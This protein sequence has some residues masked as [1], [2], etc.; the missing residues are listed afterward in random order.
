MSKEYINL[1]K[2]FKKK[3]LY[4]MH[5]EKDG[6]SNYQIISN[7]RM[8][9]TWSWFGKKNLTNFKDRPNNNLIT[10]FIRKK[11]DEEKSNKIYDECNHLSLRNLYRR[12][13]STS[14]I[15]VIIIFYFLPFAY[16]VKSNLMKKFGFKRYLAFL[17]FLLSAKSCIE[18]INE[19]N[20][21]K[22]YLFF[23][24]GIES[25]YKDKNCVHG[26]I[27]EDYKEFS[28]KNNFI[29]KEDL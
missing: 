28:I 23:F 20:I 1:C 24:L 26:K 21:N 16:L 29:F 6:N 11:L 14:Y 2:E 17:P 13:I 4:K 27:Y 8:R 3:N 18:I 15:K 5:L 25:L 9:N 10:F 12:T 22:N 19:Y 7:S